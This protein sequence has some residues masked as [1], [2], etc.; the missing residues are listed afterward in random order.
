[1]SKRR[2][3]KRRS[4]TS[5][6]ELTRKIKS[7]LWA[8]F[9]TIALVFLSFRYFGPKIGSAFL[10]FSR[11][12]DDTGPSDTIAPTAPII[13]RVP[14]ATNKKTL[15]LNGITEEGATVKLYVN[16]PEKAETTADRDGLFTF[17]DIEIGAGNN[18]LFAK[19]IDENGNESDN[20]KVY[21]IT[22]DDE[23]PEI[24]ILSPNHEEEIKNLNRRILVSGTLNEPGEVKINGRQAVVKA[25]NSFELLL[26]VD[27]GEIVITVE[28]EDK[29]GNKS[30]SSIT[31]QYSKDS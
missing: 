21:T 15:T 10:I 20:S 3:Y 9:I 18:I 14:E 6:A 1:M 31:I 23:A 26:G 2:N 8:I 5:E 25:D 7:S 13:S 27:E 12:R 29:A 28:A 16:G 30:K 24:I 17:I 22:F 4:Y 11:Y 19:A